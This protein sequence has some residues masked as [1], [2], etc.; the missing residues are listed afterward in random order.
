MSKKVRCQGRTGCDELD[1][2][3]GKSISAP[4]PARTAARAASPGALDVPGHEAAQR[5]KAVLLAHF[6]LDPGSY[7]SGLDILPAAGAFVA[8]SRMKRTT[9]SGR[10]AT[11]IGH[12]Q[13]RAR[14]TTC[15]NLR[16]LTVPSRPKRS[17]IRQ[18]EP[19]RR[20]EVASARKNF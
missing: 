20:N 11:V 8:L 1:H 3:H 13:T 12:L 9:A 6:E 4:G 2:H 16:L 7:P 17:A 18:R 5:S 19:V 15:T 14:S 10:I